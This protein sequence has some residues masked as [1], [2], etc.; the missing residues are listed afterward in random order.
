M[1]YLA[2]VASGVGASANELHRLAKVKH[3]LHRVL[4]HEA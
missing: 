1:K 3:S 4:Q 2:M